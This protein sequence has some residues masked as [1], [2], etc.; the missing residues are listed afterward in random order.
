LDR[1]NKPDQGN[2]QLPRVPDVS[3]QGL[4]CPTITASG[5]SAVKTT[6][7]FLFEKRCDSLADRRKNTRPAYAFLL[8]Q[9]A[10]TTASF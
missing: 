5:T 2:M 4:A 7:V 8:D 6:A 9:A 1:A 3:C 10:E